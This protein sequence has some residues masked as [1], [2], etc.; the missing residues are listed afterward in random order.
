[1]SKSVGKLVRGVLGIVVVVALVFVVKGWYDQ[2]KVA[3][4]RTASVSQE[5]TSSADSTAVVPV[6]G[7]Q[8]G[9]TVL[10]A[11]IALSSQPATSSPA[12]RV[13]KKGEQLL[14]VG[15]T[16][17]NWYQLRDSAGRFGYVP[18]STGIKVVKQAA[19]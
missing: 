6:Q 15:V 7:Q 13:L 17:N 2:Y 18:N 1:V 8:Q 10:A 3:Q 9:V 16:G 4:A 14:L 5:S 11:G 19:K 12:I